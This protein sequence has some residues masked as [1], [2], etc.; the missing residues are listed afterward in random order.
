M[1]KIVCKIIGNWEGEIKK[2]RVKTARKMFEVQGKRESVHFEIA[3]Q[4]PVET[5]IIRRAL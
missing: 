4:A 5:E 1:G 2:E 3:A